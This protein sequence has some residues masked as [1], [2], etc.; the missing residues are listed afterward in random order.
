MNIT[1]K[2][3]VWLLTTLLAAWMVFPDWFGGGYF[4]FSVLLA[5]VGTLT[6]WVF[7]VLLVSWVF[8]VC[9]T[10]SRL[11]RQNRRQWQSVSLVSE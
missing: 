3:S 9:G 1:K 4:R 5:A 10:F 8:R 7:L 6:L 11:M 2:I